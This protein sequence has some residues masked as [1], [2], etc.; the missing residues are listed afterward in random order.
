[1][2]LAAAMMTLGP[3]GDTIDL[4]DPTKYLVEADSDDRSP[5][6]EVEE[7]PIRGHDGLSLVYDQ[8]RKTVLQLTVQCRGATGAEAQAN[9]DKLIKKLTQAREYSLPP[10]KGKQVFFNI[11]WA[12]GNQESYPVLRGEWHPLD[13]GLEAQKIYR[14]VLHLEISAVPQAGSEVCDGVG[15]AMC[16]HDT[17]LLS[18]PGSDAVPIRATL[19]ML[20]NAPSYDFIRLTSRSEQFGDPS[21]FIYPFVPGAASPS[22][23]SVTLTGANRVAKVV[24]TVRAKGNGGQYR[25]VFRDAGGSVYQPD[26]VKTLADAGAYA[27]YTHTIVNNPA[28]D[29]P[30]SIAQLNG[31]QWG[32]QKVGTTQVRV[33]QIY[34][35]V[36]YV[37]RNLAEQTVN[38]APDAL[39]AT[40]DWT[41]TGAAEGSEWD[42]VN[43]TVGADDG[44]TSYIASSTDGQRSLFG[45]A[46]FTTLNATDSGVRAN[47][48]GVGVFANGGF[49]AWGAP[50][51]GSNLVADGDFEGTYTDGIH[52]GWKP[53]LSSLSP[54]SQEGS[55]V[56]G[57]AAAQRIAPTTG[58][59]FAG[60]LTR[61]ITGLTPGQ[62]YRLQIWMRNV[63]AQA[64]GAGAFVRLQTQGSSDPIAAVRT[65]YENGSAWVQHTIDF[66][67]ELDSITV[68]IGTSSQ[69]TA[70]ALFDDLTLQQLTIT[71]DSWARNGTLGLYKETHA[72]LIQGGAAALAI[73]QG[74]ATANYLSQTLQV[75]SGA[76]YRVRAFLRSVAGNLQ[77]KG[78]V[79]V[80]AI[81]GA[82]TADLASVRADGFEEAAATIV[83]SGTSLELR[84]YAD[85]ATTGLIDG[86]IV[87]RT[88]T[89]VGVEAL[90]VQI[91]A[92]LPEH[93]GTH[94]I[95][96]RMKVTGDAVLAQLGY[97]GTDGRTNLGN[98]KVKV[99]AAT[100]VQIV[101]LGQVQIPETQTTAD[102]SQFTFAIFLSIDGAA[103]AGATVDLDAIELWPTDENHFA[104]RT[105]TG[106]GPTT[107]QYQV[108]DNLAFPPSIH[109]ADSAKKFLRATAFEGRLLQLAPGVNRIFARVSRSTTDD[110]ITL[111]GGPDVD[112]W[113]LEICHKAFGDD[114]SPDQIPDLQ[115]WY[116]AAA[117]TGVANGNPVTTWKN[118]APGYLGLYDFQVTGSAGTYQATG[119][120]GKPAIQFSA[121]NTC[122]QASGPTVAFTDFTCFMVTRWTSESALQPFLLGVRQGSSGFQIGD[123]GIADGAQLNLHLTKRDGSGFYNGAV[124]L[125]NQVVYPETTPNIWEFVSDLTIWKN[126]NQQTT[127]NPGGASH[128]DSGIVLGATDSTFGAPLGYYCEI[129]VYRRALTAVERAKV[130]SYLKHRWGTP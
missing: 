69:A 79:R 72:Q 43:D 68:W 91:T 30:F 7:T 31:G 12:G 38:L 48:I 63:A 67:A 118:L 103:V 73:G 122:Y 5:E 20:G 80:R 1:M 6:Y 17:R 114:V 24:V 14:G 60:I 50:A 32:V 130:R 125:V 40:N 9:R 57:G 55:L 21:L 83:A 113:E 100:T 16:D 121:G 117:I 99:S 8:W 25:L 10:H 92:N 111:P 36:T 98:K 115:L 108:V 29:L 110:R 23:Y 44:D 116:D 42:A 56:H 95:Y 96:A 84:L 129:I 127:Q 101:E 89:T 104:T 109:V 78:A 41:T 66:I 87:E 74:D 34:L 93:Y 119:V 64:P 102:I 52:Q 58:Q 2:A 71:P 28:T 94:K 33:T 88:D 54:F 51:V 59:A 123:R 124:S 70:D 76:T 11:G 86:M 15:V 82:N 75:V 22:G 90:R 4:R 37:D 112:C 3:A 45:F 120:N 46:D 65:D 18:I 61:V 128:T 81:S 126:G 49:E 77:T 105:E 53:L 107:N 47:L 27:T 35:T 97:G 39:G 106:K 26:A 13:L 85:A 62:S 19:K